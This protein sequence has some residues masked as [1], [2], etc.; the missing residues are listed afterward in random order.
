MLMKIR[1]YLKPASR[2]CFALAFAISL[3][4][5]AGLQKQ[6]EFAAGVYTTV[7][8]TEVPAKFVVPLANSFDILKAAATNYAR[9]CIKQQMAPAICSAD[10]R[11]QVVR[12]V[13]SGTAARNQL[14]VSLETGQPALGSVYNVLVSAVNGLKSSPATSQQFAGAQ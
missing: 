11:R 14:E 8:E 2:L 13:R 3:S 5:C 9:Y 10:I 12:A 4:A 6:I 7:T 1:P